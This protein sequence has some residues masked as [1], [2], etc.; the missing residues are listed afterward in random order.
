MSNT[1]PTPTGNKV[2][3]SPTQNIKIKKPAPPPAL[4]LFRGVVEDNND[5]LKIGRVR[6][7]IHGIHSDKNEK[8]GA[9]F[10]FIKTSELPWAEVMGDTGFGLVGGI[11]LSSVLHQGT[12]VWIMLENNDPSKP[13][14]CGTVHGVNS[15]SAVGKA[16]SGQGFFDPS[17]QFPPV[18]NSSRTDMHKLLDD[19]YTSMQ[20]IETQSGHRVE[21]Q[22]TGGKERI[23]ITHKT[24][25]FFY[26]DHLGNKF[27][28][29][30]KDI[31][32]TVAKNATWKIG[33]NLKIQTGG[34]HT[35][36]NGGNHTVTAP[37]INL[38]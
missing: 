14:V 16:A 24:G 4:A 23:K 7:R 30:V 10:E 8:S 27:V 11:G 32:Y 15:S 29:S 20:V 33:G 36:S 26:I 35:V 31:E 34:T 17:G 1:T 6:V 3:T 37:R 18:P 12:W 21:I 22:D 38:N 2:E 9:K 13:V 19:A 28:N 25:S 5:P